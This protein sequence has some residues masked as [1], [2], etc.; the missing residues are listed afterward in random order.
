MTKAEYILL[1]DEISYINSYLE[2]EYVRLK[3]NLEFSVEVDN[4]IDPEKYLIPSMLLQPNVENA[5]LHGLLP[6]KADR[7]LRITI[8]QKTSEQL[9]ITITDNG[10]GR[11]ASLVRK[12]RLGSNHRSWAMQ[13]LRERIKIRNHIAKKKI[14]SLH[15]IDLKDG[16]KVLGTQIVLQIPFRQKIILPD[17]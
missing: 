17:N 4:Q 6:K 15:I 9:I 11:D 16:D 3:K 1:S 12:N 7:S 13:I 8:R 14:I 2:L 5:L 10:I